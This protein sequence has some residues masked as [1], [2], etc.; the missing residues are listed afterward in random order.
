MSQRRFPVPD[1]FARPS[2]LGGASAAAHVVAP[3]LVVKGEGQGGDA[4][5]GRKE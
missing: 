5:S 2:M 1:M 3:G 4:E